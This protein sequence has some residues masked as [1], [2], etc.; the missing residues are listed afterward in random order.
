MQIRSHMLIFYMD[1]K[2][3]FVMACDYFVPT[4]C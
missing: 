3:G 4:V 2:N 1:Y